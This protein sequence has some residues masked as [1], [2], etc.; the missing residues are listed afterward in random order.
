MP[1]L[2]SLFNCSSKDENNKSCSKLEEIERKLNTLEREIYG[3]IRRVEDK[4]E[5][6]F[7]L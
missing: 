5:L 4:I 7:D 6:K 1:F 3:D 2:G